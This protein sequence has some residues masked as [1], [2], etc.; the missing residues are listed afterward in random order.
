MKTYVRDNLSRAR[1]ERVV[2]Q[3]ILQ[4]PQRLMD[5]AKLCNS[6]N[7]Y[8]CRF[9]R[10][11]LDAGILTQPRLGKYSFAWQ[12]RFP[13]FEPTLCRGIEFKSGMK[14]G[15]VTHVKLYKLPW[16][17]TEPSMFQ[18]G[19]TGSGVILGW[20][21]ANDDQREVVQWGSF[22]T[23]MGRIKRRDPDAVT[24]TWKARLWQRIRFLFRI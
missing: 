16:V 4:G 10:R 23:F 12:T 24:P 6:H 21:H 18:L 2:E 8:M 22:Q 3:T 1:V 13:E 15:T 5:L 20:V 11:M 9:L 7:S 19:W 17:D 14:E